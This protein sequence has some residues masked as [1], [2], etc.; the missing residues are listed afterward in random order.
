MGTCRDYAVISVRQYKGGFW[1]FTRSMRGFWRHLLK[2]TWGYIRVFR[3]LN[4]F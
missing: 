4:D 3:D 2:L 1:E